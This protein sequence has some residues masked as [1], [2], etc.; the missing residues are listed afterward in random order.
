MHHLLRFG[1]LKK[2]MLFTDSISKEQEEELLEILHSQNFMRFKNYSYN[3]LIAK[4]YLWNNYQP[5]KARS[6]VR[7]AINFMPFQTTGY[8]LF[9]LSCLPQKFVHRFYKKYKLLTSS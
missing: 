1:L 3:I 5:A 8:G 2:E 6:S 9:I 4:K 7:K